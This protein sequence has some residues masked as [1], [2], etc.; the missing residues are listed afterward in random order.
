MTKAGF[1]HALDIVNDSRHAA[2]KNQLREEDVNAWGYRLRGQ[3]RQAQALEIFKLNAV[4]F[5]QSANTYDSLAD[6]YEGLG[7]Q[8]LAI[9]NYRRS[10]ALNPKNR[11]AA[12]RLKALGSGPAE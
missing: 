3:G 10:L 11:N 9:D 7:E 6:A 1:D 12:E 8:N 4:L 5:P 2:A